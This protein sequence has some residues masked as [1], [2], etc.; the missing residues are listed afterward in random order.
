MDY[1]LYK[2]LVNAIDIGKQLPDAVYVHES[3]LEHI[4][5]E[6]H[7]L[8]YRISKAL[9]IVSSQWNIIKFYKRDYKLTLLN[10]PDFD[11]KSYPALNTSFTIDLQKLSVRKASY[12]K[13]DN[14]P[15]LH[16]KET[17]VDTSY[18]LHAHFTDLTSEG[19]TIGLY[20]NVRNIGFKKNWLRLIAQK[21]Y[22]LNNEGRLCPSFDSP[23]VE[24]ENTAPIN[25]TI[26]RHKTAIERNQL[27]QPMQILARHDYLNG[28]WSILDYGC[29]KGDDLRELEAHGIDVSGWDP[30]HNEEGTLINS[31]IVNLGF[32]LNVIEDRSE[33]D[34]TMRRAWAYAEKLIVIAVMVAGEST[35]NQ[36]QQYKDGVITSRNTFQ[37][38]YSQGEFRY[39]VEST[40]QETAIPVG[41]GILIVFKDKLEEQTFLANRQHIKR[42]WSQKTKRQLKTY[43][44]T[45]RKDLIEKHTEL[46]SDFWNTCLELGRI[47]ANSE[48]EYSDQIRR[49]TG[50]HNKAYHALSTHYGTELMLE[51]E[52]K[53]KQDLQV[54]FALGLFEKRKPHTQ[55]PDGLKRDIKAFY[56]SYNAALE[57]ANEALFS[58]GNPAIIQEACEQAFKELQCGLMAE[59]HSYT[60]HKD[61]LGDL[62]PTLRIYVGCA[63]QLYGDLEDIQLI[64]A[65]IRSGKVS[66]MG[67]DDWDKETPCMTERI[68]IKM[69]EQD[70]DFFDYGQ[71]FVSPPL[72]NKELYV[73]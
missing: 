72:L 5:G 47:P 56:Q 59:G 62:P 12:V 34:E 22:Y 37:R 6:I 46:F 38:Y 4:P 73:Q 58:V 48:F 57:D 35:I 23:Q 70:V 24:H 20:E 68:K 32:V 66:L 67:Y 3:A 31:D 61:F 28:D 10:Y 42:D 8:A 44:P 65:H 69:R 40:L 53:R 1:K 29:G 11:T 7:R 50:S 17:F 21:G 64:K 27:S 16:R 39:Y 41:Q 33:R 2:A 45:I 55:I 60:F 43:Q 51:A 36:F 14:P 19:E 9:K 15:I 25:G 63:T 18:P 13:S 54:Y 30:A 26:D 52:A 71:R 49:I